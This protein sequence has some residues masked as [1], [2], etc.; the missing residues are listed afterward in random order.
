VSKTETEAEGNAE[1][2]AAADLGT[3]SNQ[4]RQR[5]LQQRKTSGL[6]TL[7]VC[8]G[9]GVECVDRRINLMGLGIVMGA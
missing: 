6:D 8:V 3:Q 7:C 2:E 5:G 1:A 4:N 9:G